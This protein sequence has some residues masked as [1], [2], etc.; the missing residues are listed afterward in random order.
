VW[1]L[2]RLEDGEIEAI[3]EYFGYNLQNAYELGYTEEDLESM[4]FF[5]EEELEEDGRY[6]TEEEGY[7]YSNWLYSSF[8]VIKMRTGGCL[9]RFH[10]KR[11]VV[12][13]YFVP[14]LK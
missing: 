9:T 3:R 14:C 11:D 1:T 6:D 8:T 4:G 5:D 7:P 2:N 12:R 13:F 10:R